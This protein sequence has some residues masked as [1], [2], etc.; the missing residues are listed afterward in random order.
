MKLERDHEGWRATFTL[1]VQ[2]LAFPIVV[3]PTWQLAPTSA[4]LGSGYQPR[5][6]QLPSGKIVVISGSAAPALYAPATDTWTTGKLLSRSHLEPF[7][8]LLG[9]GKLLVGGTNGVTPELWT[10]ADGTVATGAMNQSRGG[11]EISPVLVDKGLATERVYFFGGRN[12]FGG[13]TYHASAE[14]YDVA[15]GTFSYVA[16]MPAPRAGAATALLGGKILVAGGFD[17]TTTPIT[18]GLLYD[19]AAD[20]Y[21]V[22]GPMAH[23]Q[24]MAKVA[25]LPS[26]KVMLIGGE[27]SFATAT[28]KTQVF[29]PATKTFTAGPS[30]AFTHRDFTLV[31][32]SPSRWMVA[33][34][35]G[36]AAGASGSDAAISAVEVYDASTNAWTTQPPLNTPRTYVAAALLSGGRVLATSYSGSGTYEIFVPDPVTCT[37]S[38]TDCTCVDGYCCDSACTGQ[39]QACDVPGRKGICTTISGEA[40]HGTRPACTPTL[41]CGPGGACDTTCS[42]DGACGTTAWCTSSSSC[43]PKKANGAGC[44]AGNECTSGVCADGVC[45]DKACSGQCEACNVAGKEGA[46]TNVIGPPVAP[47]AACAS[48]YGCSGSGTCATGCTT[49]AQ[50]AATHHCAAGACVLKAAKG[51]SCTSPSGCQSGFCVDGRCC[52]KACAGNCEACDV[53][54]TSA[55]AR[56]CRA[57]RRAPERAVAHMPIAPLESAL[58]AAPETPRAAAAATVYSAPASRRR[59]TARPAATRASAAA[60][61]AR[62]TPAATSRATASARPAAPARASRRRRPSSAVC[63]A[64][65]ARR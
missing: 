29:D 38:S 5:V 62:A 34:G 32:L 26:G 47:R 13:G 64:A 58:R 43:A 61:C 63:P 8:V 65:S 60:A 2:G 42:S 37:T 49:D 20:T 55:L 48:G 24:R 21:E 23:V 30:M 45:C 46:C 33:G 3:D 10:E 31:Q 16:T 44:A 27:G 40:P 53:G 50:C 19:L 54:A 14:R 18:N 6:A 57:D 12:G 7:A 39:C 35:Y 1:D 56:R 11:Y 17:S 41:L 15:T 25:V 28:E 52:D 59:P 51:D 9:T 36:R 4:P 22:V